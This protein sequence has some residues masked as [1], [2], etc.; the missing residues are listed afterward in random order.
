[1][2]TE[3]PQPAWGADPPEA[4]TQA[5]RPR[6]SGRKTAAAAGIAVVIA[7]GGGAAIWAA[8]ANDG[9]TTPRGPGGGQGGPGDGRFLGMGGLDSA[10]HGE[11]VMADGTTELL[12]TGKVT[13]VS[14]TSIDLASTDGYTKSYTIN[15]ATLSDAGVKTGDQVTV[16]AKKSDNAAISVVDR[17][18]TPQDGRGQR[19][20]QPPASA[21]PTT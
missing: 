19:G 18:T 21:P 12:Q 9:G 10:L 6:W 20:Q 1:M 7:A 13:Q 15:S 8:T 2:S 11:F 16:I 4:P 3:Q 5:P 14:A 17:T